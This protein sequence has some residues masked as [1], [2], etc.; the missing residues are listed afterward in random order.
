[1][2]LEITHEFKS[3]I[4][5]ELILPNY[6][7]SIEYTIKTK[8][9]WGQTSSICFTLSTVFVGISSLLS[10]ANGQFNSS[11]LNYLAG[12]VGLLAIILDK[13]GSYSETQD[14][15]KTKK[16]NDILKHIGIDIK[17]PDTS[18]YEG[19]LSHLNDASEK[20]DNTNSKIDDLV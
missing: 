6:R 11:F 2:D 12:S 10:F 13:F 5:N 20:H 16:V 17:I 19:S 15:L 1:M 14:S 7:D 18:K 4:I 9:C 8:D 3:N